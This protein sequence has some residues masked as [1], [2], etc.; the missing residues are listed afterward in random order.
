MESSSDLHGQLQRIHL[1]GNKSSG[2]AP[3]QLLQNIR[4]QK[5]RC[6]FKRRT[7]NLQNRVSLQPMRAALKF[8]FKFEQIRRSFLMFL[9]LFAN[10]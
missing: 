5:R 8:N 2:N 10:C 4:Q 7:N 3:S 1:S 6:F 9:Y